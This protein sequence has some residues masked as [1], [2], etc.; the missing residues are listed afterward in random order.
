MLGACADLDFDVVHRA[1]TK[2]SNAD[3]LSRAPHVAAAPD[4][5]DDVAVDDDLRLQNIMLNDGELET[6]PEEAPPMQ[7]GLLRQQLGP[8][9]EEDEVLKQV[10]GWLKAG[11]WPEST[12]IAQDAIHPE[13]RTYFQMKDKLAFNE[14]GLITYQD[15]VTARR[16]LCLPHRLWQAAIQQAHEEGGHAGVNSTSDRLLHVVYFP[17]LRAEVTETLKSCIPC[18][19]KRG[20]LADQRHTLHSS[21]AGFPF[22]ASAWISLGLCMKRD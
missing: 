6:E 22:S 18:Q 7:L 17:R 2:H 12:Q 8:L 1:G 19:K 21:L 3:S 10:H 20:R 15:P 4:A 14:E 5:E 13:A 11:K 9:Q 16:L